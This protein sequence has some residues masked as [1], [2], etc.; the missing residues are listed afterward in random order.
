MLALFA[1]GALPAS[2]C[3]PII[4]NQF[5]R[6]LVLRIL[7]M[8]R[9]CLFSSALD[10]V[11][12]FLLFLRHCNFQLEFCCWRFLFQGQ[13]VRVFQVR[14]DGC[15]FLRNPTSLALSLS[16]AFP[17]YSH[18]F[19]SFLSSLSSTRN[20]VQRVH[21]R[22]RGKSAGAHVRHP[23]DTEGGHAFEY[24]SIDIS[25]FTQCERLRRILMRCAFGIWTAP[26]QQPARMRERERERQK[27]KGQGRGNER[28]GAGLS[29]NTNGGRPEPYNSPTTRN[30]TNRSSLFPGW[31]SVSN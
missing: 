4:C 14:Q 2:P 16:L 7:Q 5:S 28:A 25:M 17:L 26:S 21:A 1:S 30:L 23:E 11:R 27:K 18:L 9:H 22:E 24:L 12:P 19:S 13:S 8:F 10:I 15:H 29:T 3:S 31:N 20:V 6:F